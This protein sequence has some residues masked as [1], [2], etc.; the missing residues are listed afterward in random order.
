MIGSSLLVPSAFSLAQRLLREMIHARIQRAKKQRLYLLTI[1]NEQRNPTF[2]ILGST[3]NVYTVSFG[4]GSPK[5]NCVD[6]RVRCEVRVL[7]SVAL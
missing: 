1:T 7:P 4:N 5:C 6:H 2:A 3:G